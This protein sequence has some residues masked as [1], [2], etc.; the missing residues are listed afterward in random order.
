MASSINKVVCEVGAGGDGKGRILSGVAACAQ[1]HSKGRSSPEAGWLVDC[2]GGGKE[3][4]AQAGWRGACL[5]SNGI[6]K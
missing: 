5:Y 1:C 3:E 6:P 4:M 2:F